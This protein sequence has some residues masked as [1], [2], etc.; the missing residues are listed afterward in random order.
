MRGY[1]WHSFFSSFSKLKFLNDILS[2]SRYRRDRPGI[3]QGLSVFRTQR[4]SEAC[5][6]SKEKTILRCSLFEAENEL[7]KDVNL[8][9][10]QATVRTRKLP[11]D[12]HE[13]KFAK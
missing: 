8:D 7:L 2:Y 4:T 12:G 5:S 13:P 6:T 1:S 9:V 11:S 3:V 10:F